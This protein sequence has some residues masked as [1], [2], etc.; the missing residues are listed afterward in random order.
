M[1]TR[2]TRYLDNQGR[3][4]LPS[5]I[6][7]AL[8]LNGGNCVELSLEDDGTIR[9]IPTKERCAICGDTAVDW[10]CHAEVKV[11]TETKKICYH[12]AQA[13]AKSMMK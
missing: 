5:H 6:R 9:I 11:G 13:I 12:C 7:K 2:S 3:V 4:I 10:T 8:N 1:A